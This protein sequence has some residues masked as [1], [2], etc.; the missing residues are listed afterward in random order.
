[1]NLRVISAEGERFQET[2]RVGCIFCKKTDSASS[3]SLCRSNVVLLQLILLSCSLWAIEAPAGTDIGAAESRRSSKRYK[4][5][6]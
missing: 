6:C 5:I 2:M 4:C 3:S 1:M